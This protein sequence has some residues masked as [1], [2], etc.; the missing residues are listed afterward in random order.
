MNGS[1]QN[2]AAGCIRFQPPV[3]LFETMFR[4][5]GLVG[6]HSSFGGCFILLVGAQM[7][8]R[9]DRQ[10]IVKCPV[11]ALFEPSLDSR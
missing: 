9:K 7:E 10:K 3:S 2:E 6:S 11:A 5:P 1:S 8:E 4:W